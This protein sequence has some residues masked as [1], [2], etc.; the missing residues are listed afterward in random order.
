MSAWFDK[1][2]A[3]VMAELATNLKA[4]SQARAEA[5]QKL[6]VEIE[7]KAEMERKIKS[8]AER[9][10]LAQFN[11]YN[12]LLEKAEAKAKDAM[13]EARAKIREAE[14][15]VLSYKVELAQTQERLDEAKEMMKSQAVAR[16]KAEESLEIESEQRRRIEAELEDVI[17]LAKAKAEEKAQ[18]Y[19]DAL[20]GGQ[21][22]PIETNEQIRVKP[23]T[24]PKK[25]L[26][27]EIKKRKKD[28][29][30]PIE[31][32]Y[33]VKRVRRHVF[34]AANLKR[35]F[36]LLIV[37]AIFSAITFALNVNNDSPAGEY[38]SSKINETPAVELTLAGS[39]TDKEQLKINV[40][41]EMS[42]G[43]LS[44]PR[45]NVTNAPALNYKSEDNVTE[46]KSIPVIKTKTLMITAS[47]ASLKITTSGMDDIIRFSD[48]NRLETKSGSYMYYEFSDVSIS[49][50]TEIK[51]A[52]LFVE[53]YE[54]ERFAPGK[55]E[56]T[57]GRGR[58]DKPVVWAVMKA[59]VHEG[60]SRETVDAW[61]IT[62]VVDSVEKIN[63]LQ[64]QIN[65]N[66]I[67]RR[68]TF[69]DSAYVVVEYY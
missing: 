58:P 62:S 64:L 45:P 55:L 68:K 23:V 41:S 14:E 43:N 67:A 69:V 25:S 10:L 48:N 31:G 65:N 34:N 54:E 15:K 26:K 9:M 5:E 28:F 35:K 21:E 50:D 40:K 2:T 44:R 1:K 7:S 6:K 22:K 42:L 59:P 16:A 57:I 8:E 36:I 11:K 3:R 4:E 37:I 32:I 53:H 56:W 49:A 24:K 27:T 61:D 19:T 47:P 63:S 33:K 13:A 52:V 46:V 17:A 12:A 60:Q 18:P 38:I 30:E 39:N 51:S 29:K 20:T 66:N